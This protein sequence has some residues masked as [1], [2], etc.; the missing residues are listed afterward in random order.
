[1]K[2]AQNFQDE[3]V[4][5]ETRFK[6]NGFFV[7]FGACDGVLFSNSYILEN[8][9]GWSGIVCEPNKNYHADLLKN[10]NCAKDLRCVYS[11]TGEFVKFLQVKGNDELSTL[12]EYSFIAD[13]HSEK[14]KNNESY[15]IETVSLNDLLAQHNAPTQIDYLSIDTEGSEYD[16]LQAFDFN[17]YDVKLITVEHNWTPYRQKIYDLLRSHNYVRVLEN[18]SRWDDW[19]IK[20]S[21]II[22]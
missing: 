17:K 20:D 21:V 1:M 10:R 13:E 4:L 12:E 3:W 15:L 22:V 2:Y 5:K 9:Y 11:K 16:I 7:D 14:R 6:R 8:E 18:V 19:Y